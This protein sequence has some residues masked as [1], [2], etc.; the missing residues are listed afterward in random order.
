MSLYN[1]YYAHPIFISEYKNP[2]LNNDIYLS[3]IYDKYQSGG[4][5]KMFKKKKVKIEEDSEQNQLLEPNDKFIERVQQSLKGNTKLTDYHIKFSAHMEDL[6]KQILQQY[7]EKADIEQAISAVNHNIEQMKIQIEQKEFEKDQTER[8][9]NFLTTV[10]APILATIG[11]ASGVITVEDVVNFLPTLTAATLAAIQRQLPQTTDIQ[12]LFSEVLNQT[13]K[14][15]ELELELLNKEKSITQLESEHNRL[16]EQQQVDITYKNE[17]LAL[18]GIAQSALQH[19]DTIF[20]SITYDQNTKKESDEQ[21]AKE[22]SKNEFNYFWDRV[23]KFNEISFG[24]SVF[25]TAGIFEGIHV[26]SQ[27]GNPINAGLQT[28]LESLGITELSWILTIL[29]SGVT[30]MNGL[31]LKEFISKWKHKGQSDGLLEKYTI[32]SE[33]HD[34]FD[35]FLREKVDDATKKIPENIDLTEW[36]QS[37]FQQSDDPKYNKFIEYIQKTTIKDSKYATQHLALQKKF[38]M[39]VNYRLRLL[40][41]LKRLC[42]SSICNSIVV[43]I[44]PTLMQITGIPIPEPTVQF[45]AMLSI[46][47]VGI[48]SSLWKLRSSSLDMSFDIHRDILEEMKQLSKSELYK[49]TLQAKLKALNSESEEERSGLL[50]DSKNLSTRVSGL[51]KGLSIP[52]FDVISESETESENEA[53]KDVNELTRS[54]S[55]D[56]TDSV[57]FVGQMKPEDKE[58]Q[59]RQNAENLVSPTRRPMTP[60]TPPRKLTP[61]TPPRKSVP[62]TTPDSQQFQPG[63]AL[64]KENALNKDL[65]INTISEF[66]EI[67][68]FTLQNQEFKQD[69]L[70]YHP[71][72]KEDISNININSFKEILS[73]NNRELINI[74]LDLMNT[75]PSEEDLNIL[76]LISLL[77]NI[78]MGDF[79]FNKKY[80]D[81]LIENQKVENLYV[82]RISEELVKLFLDNF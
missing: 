6:R 55:S 4:M 80:V 49:H 10:G 18:A 47:G 14:L 27:E 72:I 29:T 41:A 13:M 24:V 81:K 82:N 32:P 42:Y 51:H 33:Y 60:R 43:S 31:S 37:K 63:G 39:N 8:N 71:T 69:I 52:S 9:R 62:S 44:L 40:K 16:Y 48:I 20:Q 21:R 65:S 25:V 46:M 50:E 38:K 28:F 23:D 26:I 1:K 68:E 34:I 79:D 36:L 67:F 59:A 30:L 15:K 64:I 7:T 12:R 3:N 19:K 61:R 74:A 35:E 53:F 73:K 45:I 66:T 58:F 54:Y 78:E 75:C 70:D 77:I 5:L 57:E 76:E 22:Y 2:T 17:Q 56:S 11:I